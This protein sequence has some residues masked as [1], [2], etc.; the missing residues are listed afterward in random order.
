MF[1]KIL[2]AVDGSAS[3]NRAVAA[4]ADLA[5][6]YQAAV[7]ILHVIRNFALPR[8]IMEMLRAGEVTQSRLEILQD[9]AE[10]ILANAREKFDQANVPQVESLYLVGDPASTI[11]NYAGQQEVDLI[12]LG[13]RGLETQSNLLGGV[14]RKVTNMA[15]VSCLV[16]A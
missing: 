10:I 6:R 11:V 1:K 12:V 13:Q 14:A 15:G 7:V 16:V 8:E 2:V 3:A 9:S 5:G 4:A